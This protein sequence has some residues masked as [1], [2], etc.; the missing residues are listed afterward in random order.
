MTLATATLSM[1]TSF[2]QRVRYLFETSVVFHGLY[3]KLNAVALSNVK[4]ILE[5]QLSVES[6]WI[7]NFVFGLICRALILWPERIL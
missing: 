2:G 4:T 6:K 7:P 1:P 3:H 5:F